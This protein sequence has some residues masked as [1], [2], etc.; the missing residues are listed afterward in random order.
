MGLCASFT[1]TLID[2]TAP[3]VDPYEIVIEV[4]C[5][6]V[7]DNVFITATDNCNEVE[8]TYTDLEVSGTCPYQIIRTYTVTDICGNETD[9]Q[10]IIYHRSQ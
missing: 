10:Q 6:D 9:A 3:V 1:I 4:N 2:T 8:I 7:I 5:E